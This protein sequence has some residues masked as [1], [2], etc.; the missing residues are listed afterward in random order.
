M[1]VLQLE[2]KTFG[3][4]KV[5]EKDEE[6][7]K[8]KKQSYWICECQL[9]GTKK[10]VR[11]SALNTG[12]STKCEACNRHKS[13]TDETNKTYGKLTVKSYAG[14]KKQRKMWL[15]ECDCGNLIEVSTTDLRTGS[16]S[17]CGK[18]P[19]KQSLGETT[20]RQILTGAR[21]QYEQEYTFEDLTYQNGAHPRFDFY[22]PSK[23]YIIEYD[24]KQHFEY[25]SS[26]SSWNTKERMEQTQKN[27]FFKNTYCFEHN[28][29][30]IRIP[31]TKKLNE[32]TIFDLIPETSE[33]TLERSSN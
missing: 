24:G 5:I 28:I 21:V 22:I 13:T 19:E 7:S 2:G 3:Y 32:I 8:L 30:I 31:Y 17:S 29:P 6:Q 20:I 15:C 18:C 9:C 4:W 26:K 25:S 12:K 23:N 14:I 16:V 1:A 33:F 27:D 11:G 10:S